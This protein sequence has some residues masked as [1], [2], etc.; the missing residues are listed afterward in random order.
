MLGKEVCGCHQ[1]LRRLMNPLQ[2]GEVGAAISATKPMH[3]RAVDLNKR[4]KMSR[5]DVVLGKVFGELHAHMLPQGAHK[6]KRKCC[7]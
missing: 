2:R 4:G 5:S 6:G 3:G 1:A 7:P